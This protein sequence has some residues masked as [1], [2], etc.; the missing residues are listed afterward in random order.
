MNQKIKCESCNKV[1]AEGQ[2]P[3]TVI[4]NCRH[5][6][7]KNDLKEKEDHC[8]SFT[9]RLELERK[10]REAFG[11]QVNGPYMPI[12]MRKEAMDKLNRMIQN[13]IK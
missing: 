5:C 11:S 2:L 8:Q 10:I 6:G 4:I 7:A 3:A 13:M 1:I 12:M 9:D